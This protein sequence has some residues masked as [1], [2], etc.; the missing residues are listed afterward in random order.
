M[1]YLHIGF[2]DLNLYPWDN[3]NKPIPNK[4]LRAT[5]GTAMAGIISADHNSI[6]IK[7]IAPFCK[8]APIKMSF[9]N[10][11]NQYPGIYD[12]HLNEIVQ[13]IDDNTGNRFFD[14]VNC[15]WYFG[16]PYNGNS[17]LTKPKSYKAFENLIKNGRFGRGTTMVACTGNDNYGSSTHLSL[18]APA[19]LKI[20]GLIA[21]G[22]CTEQGYLCNYSNCGEGIDLVAIAGDQNNTFL[23]YGQNIV[24][25]DLPGIDGLNPTNIT[26]KFSD[27]N[28]F[29]AFNGYS[30]P[31]SSFGLDYGNYIGFAGGTSSATAQVTG[32]IAL[33]LSLN[34][35]LKS[36]EIETI[37]KRNAKKVN[38]TFYDY[39]IKPQE[40]GWSKQLGYGLLDIFQSLIDPV[41]DQN[42]IYSNPA[43][44]KAGTI[45]SGEFVTNSNPYG[46][47]KIQ[48]G[49]DLTYLA[50][51]TIELYEGFEVNNG[52][53]LAEIY[54]PDF[55]NCYNWDKAPM[56][57]LG[58]IYTNYYADYN[59]Q[60]ISHTPLTNND[61]YLAN[62][63]KNTKF[64]DASNGEV[65]SKI[66]PIIFPNPNYLHKFQIHFGEPVKG[67]SFKII[68]SFGQVVLDKNV[69][70][71]CSEY[72][73]NLN[74]VQSGCYSVILYLDENIQTIKLVIL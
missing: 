57:V 1:M 26:E 18:Q 13:Y 43:D 61:L 64:I 44:V 68:D 16:F 38:P 5:H 46:S 65:K 9:G 20:N 12:S 36:T 8:I 31:N 49:G 41:W 4:Y 40:P 2:T 50:F 23:Y 60:K 69:S 45:Y 25:L 63:S 58:T 7:G 15:S 14:V 72:Y 22:A 29:R 66:R 32:A 53:F 30:D 54:M 3:P 6:G 39:F 70:E 55:P 42:I 56:P 48:T 71:T 52:L 73:F 11:V 67:F 24:S 19:N 62:I 33:L 21:V 37:L 51:H 10:C 74:N 28:Q 35:C 34:P 27:F 17:P 59:G 47:V